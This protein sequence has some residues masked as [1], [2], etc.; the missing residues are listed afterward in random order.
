[1]MKICEALMYSPVRAEK[2]ENLYV[3]KHRV[4]GEKFYATHRITNVNDDI[5][6]LRRD[7]VRELIN[8]PE[9][10]L[11]PRN[12]D[13]VDIIPNPKCGVLTRDFNRK[14][15][16]PKSVIDPNIIAPKDREKT[17]KNIEDVEKTEEFTIKKH[18]SL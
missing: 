4:T 11:L 17:I 15:E 8:N 5:N 9:V 16:D 18:M 6:K 2:E 13:I 12:V 1:M 7:I 3:C 10:E 14:N